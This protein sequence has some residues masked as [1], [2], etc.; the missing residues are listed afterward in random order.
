MTENIVD[1]PH[2]FGV[3]KITNNG[4]RRPEL[5][6]ISCNM[7]LVA[8]SLENSTSLLTKDFTIKHLVLSGGGVSGF[9][10]YGILR[11][12]HRIGLWKLENIET[13][14]GTSIG[15]VLSVMLALGYECGPVMC[16][17]F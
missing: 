10:F 17:S 3:G 11:E 8:D 12:T 1:F 4:G 9:T 13:M 6:D 15:A 5:F 7:V 16:F 14:Y 2:T